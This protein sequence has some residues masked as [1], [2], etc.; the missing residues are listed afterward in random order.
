LRAAQHTR[1]QEVEDT[2]DEDEDADD[3]DPEDKD[4]ED[5]DPDQD[6]PGEHGQQ[7]DAAGHHFLEHDAR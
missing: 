7:P 4:P 3:K 1:F 2:A 5:K 6:G